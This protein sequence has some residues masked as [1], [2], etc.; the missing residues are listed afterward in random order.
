MNTRGS[1][2]C[3]QHPHTNYA[4][5]MAEY[6]FGWVTFFSD[7]TT[8]RVA[9]QRLTLVKSGPLPEQT[10]VQHAWI[11]QTAADLM[12]AGQLSQAGIKSLEVGQKYVARQI[13]QYTLPAPTTE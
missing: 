13:A 12:K 7:L 5:P 11:R 10:S 9:S 2:L 4:D 3:Y 6:D 1:G 8:V